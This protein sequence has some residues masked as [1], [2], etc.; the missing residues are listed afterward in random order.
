MAEHYVEDGVTFLS[1]DDPCPITEDYYLPIRDVARAIMYSSC[2]LLAMHRAIKKPEV[3]TL[4]QYPAAFYKNLCWEVDTFLTPWILQLARAKY[5]RYNHHVIDTT[6]D[7]LMKVR[8]GKLPEDEVFAAIQS[9]S[10]HDY[11]VE[12]KDRHFAQLKYTY[13][14]WND[15]FEISTSYS[16]P[17]LNAMEP[18]PLHDGPDHSGVASVRTRIETS[19][20]NVQAEVKPVGKELLDI[21]KSGVDN[22]H[23]TN[24]EMAGAVGPIGEVTEAMEAAQEILDHVIKYGYM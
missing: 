11:S 21:L 19:L 16:L 13:D 17:K 12:W 14:W 23:H 8:I 6:L 3:G 7:Q 5:V 1:F 2:R 15:H 10:P 18:E 9:M 22:L 24:N 4:P 20:M